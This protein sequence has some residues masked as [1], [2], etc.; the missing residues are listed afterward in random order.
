MAGVVLEMLREQ[1][2]KLMINHRFV[3]DE[4]D[5]KHMCKVAQMTAEI[6]CLR[7]LLEAA[8]AQVTKEMEAR[9]EDRHLISELGKRN[10]LLEG[11]LEKAETHNSST[12]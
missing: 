11:R 8:E 9:Q 1:R 10:T 12:K 6:E 2:T 4:L 3:T 7:R 5:M